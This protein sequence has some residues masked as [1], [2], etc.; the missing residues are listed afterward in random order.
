MHFAPG[1]PTSSPTKQCHSQRTPRPCPS[2]VTHR[3]QMPAGGRSQLCRPPA[4]RQPRPA[5][6]AAPPPCRSRRSN[7]SARGSM[8]RCSVAATRA[9]PATR[10]SCAWLA[11]PSRY[12]SNRTICF[13]LFSTPPESPASAPAQRGSQRLR[14]LP[15]LPPSRLCCLLCRG[16]RLAL[17]SGPL[18]SSLQLELEVSALCLQ[19]AKLQRVGRLMQQP[20]RQSIVGRAG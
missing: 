11:F 12:L 7:D 6:P 19:Q 3:T 15:S 17:A 18:L 8:F 14:P 13:T 9:C 5:E 20:A 4:P 10:D 16:C 1:Q 2:H